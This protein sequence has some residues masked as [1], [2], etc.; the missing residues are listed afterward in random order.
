MGKEFIKYKE[1][2]IYGMTC[3]E[4]GADISYKW[5]VDETFV[6]EDTGQRIW[7]EE[8]CLDCG[9]KKI[10]AAGGWNAGP[11]SAADLWDKEKNLERIEAERRQP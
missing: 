4:C 7:L 3:A 5:H 11:I 9:E 1:G 2:A 8:F 10:E 6:D